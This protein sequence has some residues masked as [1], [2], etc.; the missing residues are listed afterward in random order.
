M[1]THIGMPAL[2]ET[3]GVRVNVHQLSA[4]DAADSVWP[5]MGSYPRVPLESTTPQA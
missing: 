4:R 1:C 3:C 2:G 5:T